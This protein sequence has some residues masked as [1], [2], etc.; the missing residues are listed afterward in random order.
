VGD[1]EEMKSNADFSLFPA[2]PIIQKIQVRLKESFA[3]LYLLT[4]QTICRVYKIT[5]A[6][7]V[8]LYLLCLISNGWFDVNERFLL[9]KIT[10]LY[11]EK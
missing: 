10:A 7:K 9:S 11:R 3:F 5:N 8:K 4:S 6:D 1:G 2:Y